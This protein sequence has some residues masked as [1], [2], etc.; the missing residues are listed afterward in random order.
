MG[1]VS[2]FFAAQTAGIVARPFNYP[3]DTVRRRL[4]MESEKPLEQRLYK[5]TLDCAKVIVQKEGMQGLYKGMLADIVRGGFAA[6]VPLL[7]QKIKD[8]MDKE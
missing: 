5:G 4:Q 8:A 2:G 3:F 6:M 1:F 7:Y